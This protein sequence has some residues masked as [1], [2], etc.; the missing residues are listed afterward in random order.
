M[1]EKKI[2]KKAILIPSIV[3]S[4]VIAIGLIVFFIMSATLRE[5]PKDAIANNIYIGNLNVSGMT[6]KE[7]KAE[8]ES[9]QKEYEKVVVKLS[10][11]GTVEEVTL[12]ELG[13]K[14]KD[15]DKLIE[16][17][18]SYGK[19]GSVWKR[20]KQL[21]DLEKVP[22]VIEV[23]YGVNK[24]DTKDTITSKITSL[25][26]QAQNATIKRENGKF[27]VTEGKSGKKVELDESV[28]VIQ[29]YFDKE[30]ELGKEVTISLPTVL[31]EPDIKTEDLEKI[32]SVLGTFSTSFGSTA[33]NRGKNIA[34]ATRKINATLLMPGEEFSA[35][36]KMAPFSKGNGYYEGGTFKDGEVIQSIG[37]GVCQVSTTLYNAVILAELEVT[38]RAPHSM[39]VGYVPFSQDAAIA[40]GYKDLKFKNNTQAPIYVEGYISNGKVVF[41]I[42]GEETR[43]VGRK[44]S[45]VS[46][47]ISRTPG[48][49]KFVATSAPIGTMKVGLAAHDKIKSRLWKVVT[50]NG[51]QVSKT[52]FNT[53]NYSAG[54]GRYEVGIGT[55]NAQAKQIVQNAIASQNEATIRAAIAQA[56]TLINASQQ[57]AT[58]PSTEPET[59]A[60]DGSETP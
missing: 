46:E 37:G 17:A 25:E 33:D 13:F 14:I 18:L 1:N 42:Y 32:K 56:Q 3:A 54:D 34:N 30:W 9:R 60:G 22:Y 43:P 47:T 36:K 29:T 38:Q 27:I 6:K 20:Y 12:K 48:N 15:V 7:L 16:K 52:V 10:A 11:E 2:N 31:D 59:N 51:V 41:T 58:P 24:S 49:M 35:E 40:S 21:K 53:S 19:K 50:E 8:F 23:Q 55:D 57:P 4:V 44:V 26:N 39:T 45:F 28:K 5:T